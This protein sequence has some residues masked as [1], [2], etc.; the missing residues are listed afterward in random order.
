MATEQPT[1]TTPRQRRVPWAGPLAVAVVGMASAGLLVA[2]ARFVTPAPLSGPVGDGSGMGRQRAWFTTSGFYP[3]E[4][5]AASG[6]QFSWTRA[7][8][9]FVVPHLD[10]SRPYTFTIVIAAGRGPDTAPPPSLLVSVDGAIR[11]RA[12]TT[13]E[14]AAYSVEIPAS[15]Q[16]RA[17]IAVDVSNTFVPGPDDT[18]ALGVTIDEVRL[19]RIG[20]PGFAAPAGALVAIAAAVMACALIVLLCGLSPLIALVTGIGA[21]LALAWLMAFDAAFMGTY[22]DRLAGISAGLVI[23]GA[24]TGLARRRWPGG[25]IAPEWATAVA[26]TLVLGTIRLALFAHPQARI[27]DAIF[28][29]HRASAVRG[30]SYF[31]TSITPR[32]FFEFPYAIALYVTALPFWRWFPTELDQVRLLRGLALGADALVGLALYF[33]VRRATAQRWPALAAAALW[34]FCRITTE[35]LCAANLTNVFGQGL[36]G[37]ALAA[38]GGMAAAGI[39]GI[40]GVVAVGG[41]LSAAFLSHFSTLSVGVPLAGAVGLALFARPRRHAMRRRLGALVLAAVVGASALAY[42]V[43]YSHFR[44]V[45]RSTIARVLS[46]EGAGEARSMVAPWSAKADRWLYELD[47]NFGIPLLLSALGG[48][49]WLIR[50][51]PDDGLSIVLG[52]GGVVWAGFAVLGIFTPVEMR[53]NLAAAPVVVATAALGLGALS[54]S[55][56]AGAWIAVAA[57]LAIVADGARQ[58]IV[59]LTG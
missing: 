54:R 45:Y 6:R 30:G 47:Q 18:R 16:S 2:A 8:A 52:T 58:W 3:P 7:H 19:E 5:D 44:P 37:V 59:C 22:A 28:Q 41:L 53:A 33:A 35:A 38:I 15:D 48:A 32:P 17:T 27:G 14:P 34:P 39:A 46:R 49:V 29:V 12:D 55:S 50:R 43:Y 31:F 56:R 42:V 11:A 4:F 24:L 1:G 51:R 21:A 10:R 36:F 23:L 40:A 25:A 57:A 26:A 20:A 9:E 13:N